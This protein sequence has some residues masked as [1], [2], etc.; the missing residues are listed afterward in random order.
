MTSAY[1]QLVDH[2]QQLYRLD[3]LAAICHWDQAAMMPV[4][5]NEARSEAMAELA[6]I[7]HRGLTAPE[8]S[9]WL[10]AVVP[11]SL[12][13]GQ[14]ANVRE[15]RRVWRQATV[16]PEALVRAQSL[17]GAR[18]EHAWRDQ[19]KQNDWSGFAVNLREVVKLSREEASVRAQAN[20][21]GRYDSL[22]DLYEPGMTAARL[23]TL[24][25]DIAGWLPELSQEIIARQSGETCTRPTGPF[26][27]ESQ[28][29]LGLRVMSQLGF[30]FQCGRL[31]ISAHPF[32]GGVP[33]DV[34]ITTRYTDDDFTVGLMGVI[35]ET[36]HGCYEQNLPINWR[37]QPAGQARS[38]GIHESQSLLFEMQLGRHPAFLHWLAPLL[39]ES[40]GD[41]V[42]PLLASDNLQRLYTR[43]KPG[44][45]RVDADEVTYP[46]HVMLRYQI[47]RALIEGNIE[48]NDI[49]ELWDQKMQA[50]LGLST[51][52]DYR[53]GCMQDIHW[54]D[55]GFGYFPTYTLGALY[56]A[57]LFAAL[58][59]DLGGLETLLRE[60]DLRPL[61][62]W[63]RERV[64]HRGSLL[65]APEL[66]REATGEELNP[67]WFRRHLEHRY[68]AI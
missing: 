33:E 63:L 31:D 52:G 35:H 15:M 26:P 2:F 44:L 43:V 66:M 6:L 4:G 36:G 7:R 32:C 24:F 30:D 1:Q 17:A 19:R 10:D 29:A 34:R 46:C 45:I 9:D 41:A 5:S 58:S 61:S 12:D 13:T 14:R 22:L 8:V 59:R 54:T 64:W 55:G 57:Q 49:P 3:H 23:D 20:G 67:V 56:A 25:G 47:E 42:S 37:G 18:C 21:G 27:V 38:M 40:F 68:L 65:E 51:A 28:R 39:A 53:N 16:L 11:H 48:V 50:G 60:G 62:D